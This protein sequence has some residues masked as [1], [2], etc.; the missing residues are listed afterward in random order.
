MILLIDNYDSFTW[1]LYDYLSQLGKEVQV[2]RNDAI[3]ISDMATMP[4]ESIVLSPGPETPNEA[5]ITLSVINHFHQHVPML[6]VCLGYQ[7]I[8]MFFGAELVR[9]ITPMHG[10]TS[11]I[12]HHAEGL[13]EGLPNPLEVMRYHSLN[14]SRIPEELDIIATTSQ[15]EPMALKHRF[16][17]LYGVQ[18]HPE[19]IGTPQGLPLLKNWLQLTQNI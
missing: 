5:G 6:G 10:K 3:S 18:F 13:F 19:S 2:Y 1:N 17:P 7:A 16:W 11:F 15:H 12:N 14:I 8:G 4:V 9:S